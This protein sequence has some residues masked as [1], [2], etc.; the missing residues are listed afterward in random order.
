MDELMEE[1]LVSK[2][3][4]QVRIK[5]LADEIAKDYQDKNPL[6][7]CVL[8]GGMPFMA[9]LMKEMDILLEIDFMDVS[10]YGDGF[11][12]S[13]EVKIVKDLSQPVKDRHVIFVEDII[14]T[15]RTLTYLYQVL[16]SR[17]AAS[18]KTVSLLDKPARRTKDFQADWI[19]F[20]IPDKFVVGY[21]LDFK[22]Q[23]RNYPQIAV[24]KK[25]VYS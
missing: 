7:V 11:E 19:G 15:G 4:L 5:E 13:G 3:D 25:E 1:I 9:D 17:Q 2:E 10:S 24:L 23:L 22:G 14:D 16:E 21:G 12:S 6:L 8:K 20:E 18:I